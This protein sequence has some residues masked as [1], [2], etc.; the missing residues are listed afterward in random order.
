[1]R[2]RNL[3]SASP[4]A[5]AGLLDFTAC[6]GASFSLEFAL[7]GGALWSGPWDTEIRCGGRRVKPVDRWARSCSIPGRK[8]DYLELELRLSGGVRIERHLAWARSDRFLLVADAV[9][10]PRSMRIEYR[11]RF[12]LASGIGFRPAAESREGVLAGGRAWARVL[13][14]SLP[15]WRAD[16]RGGSL[17]ATDGTLELYQEATGRA[18]FAACFL[19]LDRGRCRRR[20]TWRQLMVAENLAVA[21]DDVAV[22]YRVTIGP[23]HWLIYRSLANK[24]NRTVLGHNLVSEMLVARFAAGKVRPLVE[25]E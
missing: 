4:A 15:E 10:A 21:P 14:L 20:Y 9:L 11:T 22:G 6:R 1:M 5:T 8:A 13:P 24:A 17:I 18:L 12:P 19:D 3:P 23:R 2:K 7:A 25:T 16:P